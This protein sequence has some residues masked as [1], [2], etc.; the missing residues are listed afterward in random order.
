MVPLHTRSPDGSAFGE[1]ALPLAIS[2]TRLRTANYSRGARAGRRWPR[3]MPRGLSFS[4]HA[5]PR[6]FQLRQRQHHQSYLD[7]VAESIKAIAPTLGTTTVLLEGD[8]PAISASR[9][10]PPMPTSLC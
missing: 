1:H 5:L 6:E 7:G 8:I 3:S 9:P 2:I 10:W 4:D